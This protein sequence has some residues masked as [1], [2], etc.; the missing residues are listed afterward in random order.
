MKK[1]SIH[2]FIIIGF[3]ALS[4]ALFPDAFK[5]KTVYQPDMIQSTGKENE[6]KNH[7]E[8]T[9]EVSLWTNSLFSGMP[10]FYVFAPYNGN[11]LYEVEKI[12]HIGIEKPVGIFFVSMLCAYIM[13]LSLGIAPLFSAL[14][15]VSCALM[16][17]NFVIFEAGHT[18]KFIAISYFPLVTAGLILTFRDRMFLGSSI[19]G[20]AL[21]LSIRS[22]HIQM[23]YYLG[24]CLSILFLFYSCALLKEKK[25]KKLL[26]IC[27]FLVFG[28]V[29]AIGSNASRLWSSYEYMKY[30]MRGPAILET[31]STNSKKGLTKDYVFQ[32]SQDVGEIA[33]FLIPGFYGGSSQEPINYK[34]SAFAK[35]LLARGASK[36]DLKTAPLYWGTLPSTSGPTYL[37]AITL[38]L[39]ILGIFSVK[40]PLKWW[41]LSSSILIT[42]LSFGKNLAWFNDF[43]YHYFPMYS[44]FRA[45]NSIIAVLQLTVPFLAILGLSSFLK[46]NENLQKKHL[47]YSFLITG[48]ICLFFALLGGEFSD[49]SAQSD[50]MYAKYGYNLDA[51]LE[52]R[53]S[54]LKS[55][56]F[57]SLIFIILAG[58]LLWLS[59]TKKIK[60]NRYILPLS[61]LV[62][63]IFDLA[64][65]GKRYLNS[66]NF[67]KKKK[68]M[69]QFK[70]PRPVDS[71]ILQDTDLHYR[72][73]DLSI[74]TFNSNIASR[75]LK[76]IGG[77][78]AAK[79]RRY[80]DII[81]H[82]ISKNNI[83]VLNMLNTKYFIQKNEQTGQEFYSKNP[84]HYGNAWFVNN[85]KPVQ[86]D[87]EEI[88]ALNNKDMLKTAYVHEE[89]KDYTA[90]INSMDSSA[91][92]KLKEYYPD[93]LIYSSTSKTN[94]FAVFSE[95]WYESGKKGWQAYID[96]K[97]VEH[98]R[99]NYI[100]RGMK[101]PAGEHEIMFEFKPYY[102]ETGDKISLFCS[103]LMLLY[104]FF[105]LFFEKEKLLN[106]S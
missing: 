5:D 22:S 66:E 97:P 54:L 104:L 10:A 59:I 101:I 25:T 52:D 74:N 100:L 34:K 21:G 89:Y 33:T 47:K 98:I 76:A 77:Y 75:S 1:Y 15:S 49:F 18:S 23:V 6:C 78:H 42:L 51:L 68:Y 2:I 8:K 43:F 62:L 13:F 67:V 38:L 26:K 65:V 91:S 96:G 44:K 19:F 87:N 53:A 58:I 73:L 39:F 20:L 28:T 12:L 81:D 92:I 80:Q 16:T 102:Y 27:A 95:V 11:L 30:T 29:L 50:Q 55:D 82:H 93:K 57:R 17:N 32:W 86:N 37:G 103:S 48:G 24:I 56:A 72:I 45:V 46:L 88:E 90:G 99:T 31:E 60:P 83:A 71:Q 9:G 14:G 63:M 3:L 64:P 105:N 41:V 61:L 36:K 94:Q 35:D 85:I 40:G 4:S 69:T 84:N 106:D 70:K 7:Y 79:L